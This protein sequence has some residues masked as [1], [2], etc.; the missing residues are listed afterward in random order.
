MYVQIST[1]HVLFYKYKIKTNYE[2]NDILCNKQNHQ[3][4][5]LNKFI[6]KFKNLSVFEKDIDLKVL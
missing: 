6:I 4:Y 2:L 5:N 1:E 3:N